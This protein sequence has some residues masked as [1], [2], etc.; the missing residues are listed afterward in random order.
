MVLHSGPRLR[1]SISGRL[2][3]LNTRWADIGAAALSQIRE[4]VG[5]ILDLRPDA[6]IGIGRG[7]TC[8]A[9][10]ACAHE[11]RLSN[12]GHGEQR[13]SCHYPAIRLCHGDEYPDTLTR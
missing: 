2:A 11:Q 3:G 7:V 5:V 1:L 9:A 8:A 4:I 10:R 12:P 13:S 6:D